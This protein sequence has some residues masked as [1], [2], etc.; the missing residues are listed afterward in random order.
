MLTSLIYMTVDSIYLFYW[1]L[2]NSIHGAY[3]FYCYLT[4]YDTALIEVST[5]EL[6]EIKNK[7]ENQDKML[8]ELTE[9]LKDKNSNNNSRQGNHT[10][11]INSN[12]NSNDIEQ[13][14]TIKN[15]SDTS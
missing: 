13:I 2:K 6:T 12:S 1:L 7:M 8:V 3:Y 10:N 15:S 5:T 9:L 11:T 4:G 14:K